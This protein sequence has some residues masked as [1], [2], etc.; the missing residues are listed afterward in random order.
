MSFFLFDTWDFW[1]SSQK[2]FD[3]A[4]FLCNCVVERVATFSGGRLRQWQLLLYDK[5]ALRVK[6]TT[7]ILM[8]TIMYTAMFFLQFCGFS[9]NFSMLWLT[10]MNCKSHERNTT[11]TPHQYCVLSTET[12]AYVVWLFSLQTPIKAYPYSPTEL[13][14][15]LAVWSEST[16]QVAS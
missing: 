9:A 13:C 2:L 14:W 15:C 16:N 10:V 11:P 12:M 6:M 5:T 1:I 7:I 3:S 4:I 8:M